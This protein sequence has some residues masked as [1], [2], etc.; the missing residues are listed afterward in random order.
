MKSME[1]KGPFHRRWMVEIIFFGVASLIALFIAALWCEGVFEEFEGEDFGLLAKRG[2]IVAWR[3]ALAM[4]LGLVVG[5]ERERHDKPAGIR[6]ITMVCVGA[7]FL[8]LISQFYTQAAPNAMSRII[9]GI[10]TG[11]GFLGAGTIIKH[12]FNV[13]G[14]TTAATLWAAAG[15]GVAC[16]LGYYLFAGLG[17]L[18]IWTVLKVFHKPAAHRAAA[19]N[20]TDEPPAH[21]D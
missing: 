15:I 9:Q 6:T 8:V 13:E 3:L 19:N 18:A 1:P 16:G 12:E 17:T 10:I 7:C 4:M 21:D 20:S 11:I 14:L 5:L 2:V